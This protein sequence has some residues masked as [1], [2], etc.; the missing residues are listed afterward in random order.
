MSELLEVFDD[1]LANVPGVQGVWIERWDPPDG[2]PS[3]ADLEAGFERLRDA[4]EERVAEVTDAWGAPSYRGTAEHGDFP[5]WSEALLLATWDH[6]EA[7]AFLA[8][9]HDD[10]SLPMFLEAGALS[11]DEIATLAVAKP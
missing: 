5:A 6:G 3:S 1:L 4:F 2:G 9:R 8:L 11:R 10:D 7:V